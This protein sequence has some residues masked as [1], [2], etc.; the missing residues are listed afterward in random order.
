MP[1]MDAALYMLSGLIGLID[2]LIPI[3]RLGMEG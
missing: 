3:I 2:N 1:Y